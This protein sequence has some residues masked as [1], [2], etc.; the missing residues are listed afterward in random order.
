MEDWAPALLAARVQDLP[1]YLAVELGVVGKI[2]FAHSTDLH[3]D[4][5]VGDRLTEHSRNSIR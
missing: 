1:R 3:Q 4:L 5:V 2:H